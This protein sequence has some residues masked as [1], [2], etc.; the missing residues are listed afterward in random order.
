[1]ERE[2]VACSRVS[3]IVLL[4][5][6]KTHSAQTGIK[7]WSHVTVAFHSCWKSD[8]AIRVSSRERKRF[9]LAIKAYG[10]PIRSLHVFV[11]TEYSSRSMDLLCACITQYMHPLLSPPSFSKVDPFVIA[12]FAHLTHTKEHLFNIDLIF[13]FNVSIQ[14]NWP[15]RCTSR[16]MNKPPFYL[17][18]A[19]G[20]IL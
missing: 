15:S 8:L 3:R 18:A 16:G 9:F 12:I 5:R 4:A 11:I 2:T 10:F 14:I 7:Q 20:F 1:M 6:R 17:S 19:V 13:F